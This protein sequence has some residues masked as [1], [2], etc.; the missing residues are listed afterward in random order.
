MLPFEGTHWYPPVGAACR[1]ICSLAAEQAGEG[2]PRCSNTMMAMPPPSLSVAE[3]Y[4]GAVD[5][6][7]TPP[8]E[9]SAM[10]PPSTTTTTATTAPIPP[11]DT[12]LP[13]ILPAA[14][15]EPLREP[16]LII[17]SSP[18][19]SACRNSGPTFR[20]LEANT[21]GWKVVHAEATP[22][23]LRRFPGHIVALPTF[24]FLYPDPGSPRHE[25]ALGIDGARLHTVR[26]NSL[27]SL[28]EVIPSLKPLPP[29]GV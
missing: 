10:A 5:P 15:T 28:R 21:D 8:S 2:E 13:S 20:A 3:G 26:I 4:T 17:W 18:Y 16:T 9:S 7:A 14:V 1:R 24:D 11:P 6:S 22:E 27:E 19:C 25:N 29:A 12:L 23:V